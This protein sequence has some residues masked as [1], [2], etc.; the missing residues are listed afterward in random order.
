MEFLM[1]PN[2]YAQRGTG[3]S[4][5]VSERRDSASSV[6]LKKLKVEESTIAGGEA[7][8]DLIPTSL[9]LVAV[10]ELDVGVL[11]R[12]G[13]FGKLLEAKNDV[14]GGGFGP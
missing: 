5:M 6:V 10:R 8:E 14:I 2:L 11:E 1:R 4:S 12:E 13:V 3:K 7:G 9:V